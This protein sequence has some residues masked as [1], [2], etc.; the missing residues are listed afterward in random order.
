MRGRG[1]YSTGI[2]DPCP[3]NLLNYIDLH[4]TGSYSQQCAHHISDHAIQRPVQVENEA[5][6]TPSLVHDV[7]GVDRS[8]G[9]ELGE[10]VRLPKRRPL[11][12][13][14]RK[15]GKVVLP[16]EQLHRAG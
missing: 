1:V 12:H 11:V 5:E 13:L 2:S 7:G 8:A 16:H 14:V 9:I 15:P 10:S 3:E 4:T 6:V